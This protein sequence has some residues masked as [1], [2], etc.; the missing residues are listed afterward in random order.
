MS[1]VEEISGPLLRVV[2]GEP[3]DSELAA[4]VAVVAA[5]SAADRDPS[6]GVA[7]PPSRWADPARRLRPQLRP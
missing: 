6:P 7:R 4:L 1:D 5:R 2:R 3:T